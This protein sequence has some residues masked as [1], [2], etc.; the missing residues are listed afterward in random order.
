[1]CMQ[2]EFNPME[3]PRRNPMSSP[4]RNTFSS[5]SRFATSPVRNNTARK[6]MASPVRNQTSLAPPPPVRGGLVRSSNSNTVITSADDEEDEVHV[7]ALPNSNS[8]LNN[9]KTLMFKSPVRMERFKRL[10]SETNGTGADAPRVGFG[11]LS[12]TASQDTMDEQEGG[13]EEEEEEEERNT[14]GSIGGFLVN[15]KE[16]S[17]NKK[18]KLSALSKKNAE[19]FI[20]AG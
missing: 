11:S 13:R 5:P 18:S 7:E 16:A 3:S 14:R 12:R 9:R 20:Y 6:V 17:E 1:M 19:S 8:P 15:K 10:I 4:S 2:N